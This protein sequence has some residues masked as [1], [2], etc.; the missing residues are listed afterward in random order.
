MNE[1][2]EKPHVVKI[3]VIMENFKKMHKFIFRKKIQH[4]GVKDRLT[5]SFC[6]VCIVFVN[7]VNS[8]LFKKEKNSLKIK[9]KVTVLFCL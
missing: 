7:W 5:Y 8:S 4:I 6:V 3:N 2:P 9:L 1:L